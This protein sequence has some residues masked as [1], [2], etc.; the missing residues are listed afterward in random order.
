MEK[1]NEYMEE[2][3]GE[4]FEDD[5]DD[6]DEMDDD[7]V[8]DDMTSEKSAISDKKSAA[9][10]EYNL[11]ESLLRAADFENDI[12]VA[13]IRRNGNFL[14]KVH[15]RPIS[16]E[17]ARKAR[18]KATKMLSNPK[19]K[20]LPKIEGEF[21]STRFKSWIIY[22]ATT[23]EDRKQIWGNKAVMDKYEVFEPVDTIDKLLTFG[24]KN[25]LADLVAEISGMDDEEDMTE[26]EYAK[27]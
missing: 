20:R 10:K 22:L 17:E 2:E 15:L 12:T 1:Y 9:D 3:I 4:E 16:D 26:E 24:E 19:G 8:V 21:D 6:E 11:V 25:R 5:F 13:E 23:E 27:N 7:M 14:F 18:K